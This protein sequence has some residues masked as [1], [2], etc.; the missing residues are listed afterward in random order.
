MC[1]PKI[2]ALYFATILS[3]ESGNFMEKVSARA[4]NPSP[5]SE[6]FSLKICFGLTQPRLVSLTHFD[7]CAGA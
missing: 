2:S 5:V 3:A 7:H 6:F 1:G 4:E